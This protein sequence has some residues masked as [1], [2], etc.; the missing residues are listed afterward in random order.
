MTQLTTP[1]Y[2][3]DLVLSRSVLQA[4][5]EIK[6]WEL[7]KKQILE[8]W[9]LNKYLK[10]GYRALF[11]GPPGTGK[12]LAATLLGK[13]LDLPVYRN[14]LSTLSTKYIGETEKNLQKI[15][16]QSEQGKS[17]LFF[18]EA[19]ALFGK[20]TTVQNANDRYA[21]QEISYLLQRIED[22]HGLV[23]LSSNLKHNIDEASMRRLQNVIYFAPPSLAQRRLLWKRMFE[24]N[25]KLEKNIDFDKL[26]EEYELTGGE[27][28]EILRYCSLRAAQ[29]GKK[30]LKLEDILTGIK[31]QKRTS[32]KI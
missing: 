2:W 20:R 32:T 12:T 8:N 25:F 13:E 23:I 18:D 19:D 31:M 1:L 27:L 26:A 28:S 10:P 9:Q 30:E 24:D 6:D 11:Y 3:E 14:D 15:F 22:F 16:E 5:E 4:L 21:N 17:I 29:R 7:H